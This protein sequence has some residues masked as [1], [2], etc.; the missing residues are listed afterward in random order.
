L[1][2]AIC[3]LGFAGVTYFNFEKT[4]ATNPWLII[5]HYQFQG[6]SVPVTVFFGLLTSFAL[7]YYKIPKRWKFYFLFFL[8]ISVLN[9]FLRSETSFL[10]YVFIAFVIVDIVIASTRGNSRKNLKGGWIIFSGFIVLSF[11]IALQVLLDFSLIP[12]LT[13]YNQVFVY[14][15]IGLAVSMSLFLSYNFSQIN[16]DLKTQLVKVKEL[17]EKT[18]EQERTAGRLELERKI[19]D[20]ENKRKTQELEEARKLQLSLLPKE[21][22]ESENLDIAFYMN[23]AT[24]V[25]GDYYDIISG[26]D[27]RITIAVGDATGHG[28]K[29]GIM[30][31]IVKG[32]IHELSNDLKSSEVLVKINNVIREMQLGNLYM[33]LILIK[34]NKSCID[35]SS[36]GMPPILLYKRE[37]NIIEE[38]IIKRMPLGATNKLNFPEQKIKINP[39][40]I[41]L[42][43][44]DGLPEL[45][46]QKMEMFDYKRVKEVLLNNTEKTSAEIITELKSA[47]ERW[48][49]GF[50]QADDMTFVVVKCKE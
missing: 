36:A 38:I 6:I 15:M 14:G 19:V 35:I 44:S 31:A 42:L 7:I 17:S 47:A 49:G 16:K 50:E 23:T 11:F 46:N 20:A 27:K 32:L 45:F 33:A 12:P 28:V 41:L 39:G 34:I 37:E 13:E 21:I 2:Y 40:D 9:F 8:V 24:E 5:L 22:P 30:V 3:L 25:G 26:E 18:I 48:R 43:L 29:A 10:N 4:N 1:F